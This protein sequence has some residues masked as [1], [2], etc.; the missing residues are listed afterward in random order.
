MSDF[1]HDIGALELR[2]PFDSETNALVIERYVLGFAA[3][4]G[5]ERARVLN[6]SSEGV[7][8]PGRNLQWPLVRFEGRLDSLMALRAA[9]DIHEGV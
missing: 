8:G 1:T 2:V 9:F 7:V 5:C 3:E 4:F 6:Y